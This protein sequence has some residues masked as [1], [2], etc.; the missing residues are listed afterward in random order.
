MVSAAV[1][2]AFEQW[3]AANEALRRS[4]SIAPNE[5]WLAA[6]RVQ[7]AREL[8]ENLDARSRE[9]QAPDV[10][11]MASTHD[12]RVWLAQ[13]YQADPGFRPIVADAL[14]GSTPA[15]KQAFLKALKSEMAASA[16]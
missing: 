13:R 1:E 2:T 3:A 7:L 15:N 12:G 14:E 5:L 16:L 10:R 4:A 11:L 9:A 8:G 6:L